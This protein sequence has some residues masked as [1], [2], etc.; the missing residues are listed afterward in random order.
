MLEVPGAHSGLQKSL[1]TNCRES[2]G[3]GLFQLV[4]EDNWE[5]GLN[6]EIHNTTQ[7]R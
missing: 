2:T 7:Q 4:N 3:R 5:A 6:S 1:V